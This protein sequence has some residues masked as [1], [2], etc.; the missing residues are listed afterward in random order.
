M[1]AKEIVKVKIGAAK[2]E[3]RGDIN[4]ALPERSNNKNSVLPLH[5]RYSILSDSAL[6][7]T[8]RDTSRH[9]NSNAEALNYAAIQANNNRQREEKQIKLN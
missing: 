4:G 8:K 1:T 5:N 2:S 3:N 6:N 9:N 7:E